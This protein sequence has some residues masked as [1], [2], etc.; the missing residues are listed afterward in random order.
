MR[1][2]DDLS[3][4]KPFFFAPTPTC[5][6]VV[7]TPFF[8]VVFAPVVTTSNPGCFLPSWG[9]RVTLPYTLTERC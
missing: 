7:V 2:H 9:G 3:I 8:V 6:T 1:L 4:F 5:D